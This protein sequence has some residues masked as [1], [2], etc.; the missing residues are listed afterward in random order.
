MNILAV[1]GSVLPMIIKL[2]SGFFDNT[3]NIKKAILV[4]GAG[5]GEGLDTWAH[6]TGIAEKLKKLPPGVDFSDADLREM[7]VERHKDMDAMREELARREAL[8][9]NPSPSKV[10]IE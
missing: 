10:P 9:K 5:V 8:L 1:L 7:H 3:P 6:L 2:A 4:A